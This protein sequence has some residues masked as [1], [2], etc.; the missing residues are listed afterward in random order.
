MLKAAIL[1]HL[2]NLLIVP[3]FVLL[4]RKIEEFDF[5]F[6]LN[7]GSQF[8]CLFVCLRLYVPVNNSSVTLE[9]LPGFNQY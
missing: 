6:T 9:L 1:H 7:H 8:V 5:V 3:V 2:I 4:L